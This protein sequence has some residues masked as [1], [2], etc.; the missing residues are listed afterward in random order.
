LAALDADIT[1]HVDDYRRKRDLVFERLSGAYDL[2]KPG[3]GFYFFPRVPDR[4]A[5]ATAFVEEAVRHNVLVIPGS[6]FSERDTHFRLSYATSDD[7]LARGCDVLC[8][9]A[10]SG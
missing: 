10:R 7:K 2:V 9:L 6:V 4:F 5:S 1:G 3:G 8:D